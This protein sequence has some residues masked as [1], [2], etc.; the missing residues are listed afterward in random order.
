V[1]FEFS[2]EALKG[3]DTILKTGG[4]IKLPYKEKLLDWYDDHGISLHFDSDAHNYYVFGHRFEGMRKS[5][6]T[7]REAINEFEHWMHPKNNVGIAL[8]MVLRDHEELMNDELDYPPIT[9]K[10]RALLKT[11]KYNF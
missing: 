5:F 9:K 3:I 10:V 11:K 6:K 1:I 7:L 4:S 2:D 8:A